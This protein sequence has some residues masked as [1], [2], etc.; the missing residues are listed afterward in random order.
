MRQLGSHVQEA[1]RDVDLERKLRARKIFSGPCKIMP[2]DG[3][4][5]DRMKL[6]RETREGQ[7]MATDET[8]RHTHIREGEKKAE[9]EE[10][11]LIRGE[12]LKRQFKKQEKVIGFEC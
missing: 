3:K 4:T 7:K 8:G 12:M 1:A 10:K 5:G 11:Q 9:P 6:A 2:V